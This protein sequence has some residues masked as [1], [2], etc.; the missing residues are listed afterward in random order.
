MYSITLKGNKTAVE[1][2][3]DEK[4]AICDE[5]HFSP[6]TYGALDLIKIKEGDPAGE[7]VKKNGIFSLMKYPG[8]EP[9]I[10]DCRDYKKICDLSEVQ[11]LRLSEP[12]PSIH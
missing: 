10:M 4:I 9:Y 6:H 3:A 8:Q 7:V 1:F 2:I 12:I 5:I 11:E